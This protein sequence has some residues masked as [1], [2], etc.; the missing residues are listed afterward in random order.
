MRSTVRRQRFRRW[1]AACTYRVGRGAGLQSVRRG[2][3]NTSGKCFPFCFGCKLTRIGRAARKT[4]R[5]GARRGRRRGGRRSGRQ[6]GSRDESATKIQSVARGLYQWTLLLWRLWFGVA[7]ATSPRGS[8]TLRP[9]ERSGVAALRATAP[10]LNTASA[11]GL[12]HATLQRAAC[13]VPFLCDRVSRP[14]RASLRA[15]Y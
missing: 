5:T 13:R 12:Q 11:S 1:H 8:Q 9:F 6:G 4:R 14:Y 15:G 3:T 2:R 10:R 7:I